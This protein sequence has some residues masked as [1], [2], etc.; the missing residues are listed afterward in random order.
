MRPLLRPFA[1]ASSILARQ[2]AIF[3]QSRLASGG[4]VQQHGHGHGAAVDDHHHDDHHHAVAGEEPSGYLFGETPAQAKKWY[5]WEPMWYFG[6]LLPMGVCDAAKIE[7]HRRL[8][9]RGETFG[10]PLPPSYSDK[11]T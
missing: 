4:S 8:A 6:Y 7:A 11:S 5:W 10:W 3:L 9:A 2:R 1:N